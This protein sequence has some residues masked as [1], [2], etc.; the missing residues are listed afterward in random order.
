MP[1]AQCTKLIKV[2]IQLISE[3]LTVTNYNR[4]CPFRCELNLGI[5]NTDIINRREQKFRKSL[6]CSRQIIVY[7]TYKCTVCRY[8]I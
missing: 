6:L 5:L 4:L 8:E 7:E 3:L 1:I 2:R